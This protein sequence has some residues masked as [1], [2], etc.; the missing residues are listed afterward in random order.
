MEQKINKVFYDLEFLEET[1]RV[2]T[3]RFK[4]DNILRVIGSIWGI[5]AV[6]LAY[7]T[8]WNPLTISIYLVCLA[9]CILFWGLSIPKTPPTID[10]ISIGMVRDDGEEYYAVCNEFNLREAWNRWDGEYHE[11]SGF[12]KSY[13]FPP[14]K[15]YW[16]RENVLLPIWR[17]LIIKSEDEWFAYSTDKEYEEFLRSVNSGEGDDKFTLK[18]L[19]RLLKKYGKSRNQI[20]EEVKN[21][22]TYRWSVESPG[23]LFVNTSYDNKCE[24]YGYYSAYDHVALCWLF[25]KMIDLPK[26]FPMYTKDLKQDLDHYAISESDINGISKE[27][28]LNNVKEMND[29]P[30][31][32]NEH[33]ALSDARWNKKLYEFLKEI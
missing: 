17:E 31:Q 26:G 33:N 13:G 2:S 23:D 15:K 29:Y 28:A 27:E 12:A 21:F 32:E 22:C 16:I 7:F 4:T 8:Y 25:G 5:I 10:L 3:G 11:Q 14:I 9:S 18:S 19:K 30:K 1:Q 20:A 6:L 24:L